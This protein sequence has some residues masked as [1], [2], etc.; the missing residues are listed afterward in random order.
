M[1]EPTA[2][3]SL[4]KILQDEVLNALEGSDS[5]LIKTILNL[6]SKVGKGMDRVQIPIVSGLA[7]QDITSGTRVAASASSMTFGSSTLLLDQVKQVPQYID[8]N[9][10][11]NSALD[12]KAAFIDSAPR[13]YAE[14][15]EVA[16][17][18]KL[19]TTSANDF[20][21]TS[22][23]AGVFDIDDIANAKKLMDE[24]K[25]P[26]NDRWM[27]V[28]ASAMEILASFTQFEDGSKSLSEEA[29]KAGVVSQVKGFKVVQS[30]DVG[31]ATA[32]SN[33]VHFYHRTACAFA[34]QDG[35]KLVEQMDESFGQEFVALRG[36]YG[37]IDVDNAGGAG[38][39]KITMALTTA[40]S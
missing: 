19:A 3:L 36:K 2:V 11:L 15:I 22:A 14:G 24:G 4:N 18:A 37:V 16:I 9:Q 10:D 25:V 20:D 13:I 12:I 39:R 17:A 34:L 33:E 27:A 29:L 28:N 35:I 38:K 7:L 26:Y 40:T 30:E 32:A 1:A 8:Y 23:T 5:I 6:T 31:S 21:S